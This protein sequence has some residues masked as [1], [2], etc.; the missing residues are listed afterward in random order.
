MKNFLI[1]LF[2]KKVFTNIK[3]QEFLNI[4]KKHNIKKLFDSF[5]KY[6]DNAELRYVGGCVRKILNNEEIDDI[7]LAT[8]LTPEEVK[9]CLEFNEIKYFETGLKHGTITA[10]INNKNFE[11]TSLRKDLSS[12][13]R[14]AVVEFTNDW[15]TDSRRRDF[16]INSIYA[17]IH[18]NLFDPFDGRED[19]KNGKIKFI[20]DP[21]IRIQEDYLRILRYV[22]FFTNY[23]NQQ[24]DPNIKKIIKQNIHGVINL[25]KERLINELKKIIFSKNFTKILNDDFCMEIML[26]VFPQIKYFDFLK[27]PNQFT[28]EIIETKDFE[29]LISLMIVDDTDNS[30]YFL[31]KFNLSNIT[32]QRI[33]FLQ[34]INSNIA[35][36]KFFTKDN[37]WKILYKYN[38]Q[39]LIDIF[40]FK[41]CKSKKIDKNIVELKYFFQD[42]K[43]P[44]FPIKAKDIME[45]YKIKESKHLGEKLKEIENIW[46]NNSFKISKEE[47]D[48][49]VKS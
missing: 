6:S 7:D 9:K 42:K 32:K 17:D 15:L 30:E 43:Q 10:N 31:Y 35:D 4:S 29:I 3:N 41:L 11:I 36:R 28:N 47:I 12:D 33:K 45:K 27:N 20:G 23:S 22:R 21:N 1:K 5:N 2:E 13:G 39:N 49:V 40:K 38:N 8:N 18:G 46:I 16:T 19:I 25:S 26:L 37:L 14:H 34:S 48:K 24:H 44:I